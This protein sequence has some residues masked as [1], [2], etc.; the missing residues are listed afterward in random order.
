M[1]PRL[2]RRVLRSHPPCISAPLLLPVRRP[3]IFS[4]IPA[5][6]IIRT[7]NRRTMSSAIPKI[8]TAVQ[9]EAYGGVEVLQLKKDTPV[10]EIKPTELLIKNEYAGI[11][12]IDTVCPPPHHGTP[13]P[14]ITIP[15]STSAAA[16]TMSQHSHTPWAAK[17]KG[18][19]RPSAAPSLV[20]R[21][22][23]VW[24]TSAPARRQNTRR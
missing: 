11:N 16:S 9:I 8:Q 2:A 3:L 6:Q 17:P 20:I 15:P 23:T 13:L 1:S 18:A 10:P 19:S 21:S 7:L 12:F 14:M 4:P 22:A 24:R 5:G